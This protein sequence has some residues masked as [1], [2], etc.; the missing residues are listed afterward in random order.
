MAFSTTFT[1]LSYEDRKI[2][3]THGYNRVIGIVPGLDLWEFFSVKN[4]WL[5]F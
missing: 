2:N 3:K 4:F 1:C 5:K